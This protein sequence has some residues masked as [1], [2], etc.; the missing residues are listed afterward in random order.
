VL[1]SEG[2]S[3]IPALTRVINKPLGTMN[4][5]SAWTASAKAISFLGPDAIVPMLTAATNMQGNHAVWELLHN[6]ENLGTN[7]APA[8]PGLLHWAKDP[9]Y[10]VR[11]AVVSALGGIGKQP[12]LA[13]PVLVAALHDADGMVRRDAAE[14]LG[15]FA[16]DSEVVLPELIKILNGDD[17][18]A[19]GGALSGL[20]RIRSRPETVVP[21]IVPYLDSRVGR[22]AAYALLNLGSQAGFL[23]L[24]RA[25]DAPLD[26][27]YEA[28]EMLYSDHPRAE[29]KRQFVLAHLAQT[30]ARGETPHLPD[31]KFEGRLL[32]QILCNEVAGEPTLSLD[33]MLTLR[34][35]EA[36]KES[37]IATFELPLSF[38]AL[39][40]IGTVRLLCDDDPSDNSGNEAIVQECRRATN[41]NC[42]LIWE[43]H[44]DR[45]GQHFLQAELIVHRQHRPSDQGNP[46]GQ[47]IPLRGPLLS[48]MSTNSVQLFLHG[49]TYNDHGASF[50]VRLARPVGSYAL[51][52]TTPSGEHIHTI[53]GSTTNGIV[54]VHW[55]LR[56][57]GGKRYTNESL[58]SSWTVTFPAPSNLERTNAMRA[59]A[60]DGVKR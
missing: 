27:V 60:G 17:W 51:E 50:L 28:V 58:T 54:E 31:L 38:D 5:D 49:N 7:G 14:A 25:P 59:A 42:R 6:F 19:R 12:D 22:H 2:K 32:S 47:D 21:L 44:Y 56:Y 18:E 10:F 40:N 23:A 33:Q 4:D 16:D 29:A 45:P 8:V 13:V 15:T 3:A 48:F 9:D 35:V 26:I 39:T 20:G 11:A 30:Y 53:E 46:M 55:D 57:D 37:D 43:T 36:G 34:Q 1:G 24:L 52:L 41:G